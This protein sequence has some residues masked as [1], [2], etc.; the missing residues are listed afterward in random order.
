MIKPRMYQI[1]T[2]TTQTRAPQL[3]QTS[4]NT[5]PRVPISTG[6]IHKTSVRKPQLWSTH[7]KDK[8]VQNNSQVKLKKTEIVQLVIFIVDSGCTKHMTGKLKM[9]CN[10]V[11]RY[12]GTV[13]GLNHN[14][15][16][17]DQFFDVEL[18]VAFRKSTCFVSDL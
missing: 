6:V 10:F 13:E 3:P 8:V 4:R 2:R 17:V 1:D 9:L 16:S 7:M 14:L 12:L 11:E 18:E 15:F 5:N